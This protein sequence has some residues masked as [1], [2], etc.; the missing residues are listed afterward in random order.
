M[1]KEPHQ[2]AANNIWYKEVELAIK[3]KT[4]YIFL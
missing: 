3:Y 2:E 1:R 4:Y